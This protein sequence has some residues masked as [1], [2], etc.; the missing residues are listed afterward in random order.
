MYQL[1]TSP[2]LVIRLSDEA[3][4]PFDPANSDYTIFKS[5]VL[6]GAGLNDANGN[7]MTAEQIAAFVATLP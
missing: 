7:P 6:A 3:Y 5:S 2:N 1:T 4:I